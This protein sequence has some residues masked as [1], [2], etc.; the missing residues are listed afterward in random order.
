MLGLRIALE[1]KKLGLTQKQLAHRLHISPSALGMYE[2][3]RRAPSGDML[4]ALSAELGVSIDYL[5]TGRDHGATREAVTLLLMMKKPGRALLE[6]LTEE[7]VR[8]LL[9]SMVAPE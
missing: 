2:Q 4:V 8:C 7:E 6:M 5:L 1:R 9:D 3:G